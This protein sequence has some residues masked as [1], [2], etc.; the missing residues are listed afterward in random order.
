MTTAN[1]K[2]AKIESVEHVT[3]CGS[4]PAELLTARGTAQSLTTKPESSNLQMMMS[5]AGG[6]TYMAMYVYPIGAAPNGEATA[7]LR[8]LCAK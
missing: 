8:E 5:D 2:D 6:A 4:Q 3:I 7:A 1:V